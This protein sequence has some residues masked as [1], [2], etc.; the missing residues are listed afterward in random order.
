VAAV[1]VLVGVEEEEDEGMVEDTEEDLVE[2]EVD[3][4]H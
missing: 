2:E 4:D 3:M 1:V